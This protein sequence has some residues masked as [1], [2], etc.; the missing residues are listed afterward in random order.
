MDAS[1]GPEYQNMTRY[2]FHS[3]RRENTEEIL[4]EGLRC[5]AGDGFGASDIN[6]VMDD[7]GYTDP[8]PF[9]R[10][11]VVYC[12]VDFDYVRDTLQSVEEAGLAFDDVAIVVDV[13]AIDHPT[14]VAD[15]SIITDL[16]GYRYG[17]A[18]GM[19]HADTPEEAVDRY[20]ESISRVD[21][22]ADIEEACESHVHTELVVEGSIP[23]EAID[24]VYDPIE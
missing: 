16:I 18:G 24:G 21:D 23:P 17:G 4:A 10:N 9:D 1:V 8:F 20:R 19:M 6:G 15:M 13:T 14:Y 12:H 5:D 3:T 22:A 2:A 7:L 11:A